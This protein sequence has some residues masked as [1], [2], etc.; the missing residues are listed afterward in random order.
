[1]RRLHST[2]VLSRLLGRVYRGHLH[3]RKPARKLRA[4]NEAVWWGPSEW[5]VSWEDV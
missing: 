2:R 3:G 5:E 4:Q 1:M